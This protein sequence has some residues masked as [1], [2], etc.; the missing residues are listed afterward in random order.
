M[1]EWRQRDPEF[2]EAMLLCVKCFP[3]GM[4]RYLSR[5]CEFQ[6]SLYCLLAVEISGTLKLRLTRNSLGFGVGELREGAMAW[7][8]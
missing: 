4:V 3:Y 6:T 2:A 5:R 8:I 7:V 1:A